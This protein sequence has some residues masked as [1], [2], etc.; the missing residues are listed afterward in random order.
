MT[1]QPIVAAG[2]SSR[3]RPDASESTSP[4]DASPEARRAR[5]TNA[6]MSS[7][8]PSGATTIAAGAGLGPAADRVICRSASW[9][10]N[11][12]IC[13]TSSRWT[14]MNVSTTIGS[15]IV[16]RRARRMSNAASSLSA[17]RYGRSDVSASK[18]S[19]TERILAPIGISVPTTPRG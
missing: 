7:D 4:I 18:Q 12:A 6:R 1:N 10:G 11:D 13:S 17:E 15:Y 14:R 16:P 5:L 8:T 2:A 3:M 9:G 19:T